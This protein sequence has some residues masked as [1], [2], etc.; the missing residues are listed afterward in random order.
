M[1][2]A[3]QL[4]EG[5]EVAGEATGLITYMR[6]DSTR[7]APEAIEGARDYVKERFGPSYLPD[8]PRHYRK[9]KSSQ[10]AHEA[11]RPT[12]M[13]HTPESLESHLTPD[14]AR[15]Y[16]L[17]WDR[18]VACQMA[19]AVY[20]RTTVDVSAGD[21]ELRA[22][23]SVLKFPGFT[24]LYLESTDDDQ[25]GDEARLPDALRDG[26]SLDLL[27]LQPEQ[28]FT[29][30]PPRYSE[31]T[32]VRELEAQDIGRPSTYAQIIST[33]Q[34]RD[35]VTR[36]RGRF[37]PTELG[38]TVNRILVESFPDIFDVEFTARMEDELDDVENGESEWL[39]VVEDFYGP[40]SRDLDQT[41]NRRAE[42]KRSLQEETDEVCEKCGGKMVIKWGRNGRFLACAEFPKCRN[43]RPLD[44]SQ[45][46]V[47]TGEKC[48]KCGAEM[49]VKTGRHGRFLACSAYP[50]CKNTRPVSL[51]LPCLKEGCSGELV[52]RSSKRGKTFYGCSTYPDCDY[53]TWDRP[54]GEKCPLC[55]DPYLAERTTRSKQTVLRCLK[56]D[57]NI[58]P[59][60]LP[61]RAAS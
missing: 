20:D 22:T 7:L 39:K 5:I 55:G 56:C 34:D 18:F 37:S 38:R 57:Q 45:Q 28:H 51:G 19:P 58:S 31:A 16:R 54:L 41:E 33:I 53:A 27:D 43:T 49:V 11:I 52:E 13:A 10:D 9:G 46:D 3:Q 24:A 61:Q 32:L 2:V 23:G 25:N 17:I 50:E 35:Y 42:L 1:S 15:L 26:D 6:T 4:Y 8:K 36:D 29:S 40:F 44:G 14:Q 48:E 12:D 60:A 21:Y 47:S 59:D 30:P